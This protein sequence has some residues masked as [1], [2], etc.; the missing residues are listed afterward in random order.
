MPASVDNALGRGNAS[1]SY[2]AWQALAAIRA[3]DRIGGRT[4]A[5]VQNFQRK[6]GMTP[7]DGYP[8]VGLLARLRKGS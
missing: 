1:R 3:D 8:G 4:S 7:V 2:A 6:A 5:A